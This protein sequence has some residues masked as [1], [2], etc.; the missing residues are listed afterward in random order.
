[1]GRC[2]EREQ[3][4]ALSVKHE[5]KKNWLLELNKAQTSTIA[6]ASTHSLSNLPRIEKKTWTL[7]PTKRTTHGLARADKADNGFKHSRVQA[8]ARAREKGW[9]IRIR[10]NK[11]R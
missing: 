5:R 6:Q 1:L 8:Q 7:D 11:I 10:E 3:N 2:D 9:K 4:K